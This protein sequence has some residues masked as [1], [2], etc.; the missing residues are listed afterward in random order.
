MTN[1]SYAE[2]VKESVPDISD[3]QILKEPI[4]RNT[5]P[6]I[7]YAA[8]RIAAKDPEAVKEKIKSANGAEMSDADVQQA[9]LDSMRALIVLPAVLPGGANRP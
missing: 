5:A 8:F 7:A 6:C 9:V 4:G 1:D 3:E 2:L